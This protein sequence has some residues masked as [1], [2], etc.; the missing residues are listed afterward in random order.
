MTD[1]AAACALLDMAAERCGTAGDDRTPCL[2]LGTGKRM[3]GEIV[4][5]VDAEDIGQLD[6]ATDGHCL[7]LQGCDVRK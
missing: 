7:L 1:G 2:G 3:R 5:A 6:P 4:I